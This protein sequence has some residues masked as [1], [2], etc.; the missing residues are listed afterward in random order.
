MT[1]GLV[2][3]FLNSPVLSVEAG[4][5]RALPIAWRTW[6]RKQL[7]QNSRDYKLS[8]MPSPSLD[9]LARKMISPMS[10]EILS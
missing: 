10:S 8:L 6:K 5:T 2:H 9:S 3:D 1:P 7:T 4:R